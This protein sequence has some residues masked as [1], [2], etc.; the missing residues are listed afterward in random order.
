MNQKAKNLI[1]NIGA[2]L[3]VALL[4]WQAT[5]ILVY[6]LISC[7][8]A[9]IGNNWA[10][11]IEKI[12]VKKKSLPRWLSAIFIIFGFY[13]ITILLVALLFPIISGQI[14][15]ISNVNTELLLQNLEEPIEQLENYIHKW[16]NDQHF[17]IVDFAS[18]KLSAFLNFTNITEW[19][20]TLSS[21]AT[22]LLFALFSITFI[23]FFLIKDGDNIY[24]KVMDLIPHESHEKIQKILSNSI[25]QLRKYFIGVLIETLIIAVLLSISLWIAGV[26]QYFIIAII[27]ALLNIIPY[28]GP[29]SAMLIAALILLTGNYDL[30]FYDALLPLIS[31]TII[32]M[33]VVHFIDSLV[34]QPYIYSSSVNAHPLEIFLVILIT[35]NIG[36]IVAM[37]FAIPTYSILRSIIA[38]LKDESDGAK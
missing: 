24:G 10:D 9:I 38:E 26:E 12:K 11:R 8:L 32:I 33:I 13:G 1:L 3:L 21:M 28:I 17:K 16:T 36:G 19:I 5:S 23:T 35:G 20:G 27:A 15:S 30:P 4:I 2:L 22:E 25:Q 34:L 14:E 37:I 18:E 7:G 6:L 31:K 29:I